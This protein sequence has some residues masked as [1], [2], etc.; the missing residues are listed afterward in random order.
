MRI[1]LGFRVYLLTKTAM[2]W[3]VAHK[4]EATEHVITATVVETHMRM[5]IVTTT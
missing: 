4:V 3:F 5:A 1:A 2:V